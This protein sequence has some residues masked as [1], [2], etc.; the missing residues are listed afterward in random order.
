MTVQIVQP[1]LQRLRYTI[2]YLWLHMHGSAK[3]IAALT[4]LGL[5]PYFPSWARNN[6]VT[7]AQMV[8]ETQYTVRRLASYPGHM[9]EHLGT[10]LVRR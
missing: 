6:M 8:A 10:R 4:Q 9:F 3:T 1:R 5:S 7:L 2:D